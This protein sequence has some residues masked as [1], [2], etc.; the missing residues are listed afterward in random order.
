MWGSSSHA[1]SSIYNANYN[2]SNEIDDTIVAAIWFTYACDEMNVENCV[3]LVV[4]F[5][6][7]VDIMC[8]YGQTGF[9]KPVHADVFVWSILHVLC[10]LWAR[11][12]A[13]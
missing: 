10:M 12:T 7:F 3:Q 9:V 13:K 11:S 8:M 5:Q 1:T 4:Y 2:G 6:R